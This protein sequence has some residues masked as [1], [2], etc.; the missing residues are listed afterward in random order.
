MLLPVQS[1]AQGGGGGGGGGGGCK[2]QATGGMELGFGILDP[3]N[4]VSKSAVLTAIS[5]NSE[6]AGDCNPTNQTMV[7]TATNGNNF[8]GSRRM[9]NGT[10]FIPYALTLP[11]QNRPGNNTY[12]AIVLSATVQGVDYQDATAGSY[13]DTVTITVSP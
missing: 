11:T 8:S 3:S 7:I 10:S 9:T 6:K 5:L 1:G 2:W 4:A 13:Q 12:I